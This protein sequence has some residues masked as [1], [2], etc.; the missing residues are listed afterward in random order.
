LTAPPGFANRQ[1]RGATALNEPLPVKNT[2]KK[3]KVIPAGSQVLLAAFYAARHDS[4]F[5]IG[6]CCRPLFIMGTKIEDRLCGKAYVIKPISQSLAFRSN[7]WGGRFNVFSSAKRLRRAAQID[8][9]R[10]DVTFLKL[11]QARIFF[12]NK[13]I[14]KKT[15]ARVMKM[16]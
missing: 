10:N 4:C 8:F 2:V 16:I 7:L 11:V 9:C 6:V 3:Y 15:K 1:S 12:Y 5:S 14:G 13:G